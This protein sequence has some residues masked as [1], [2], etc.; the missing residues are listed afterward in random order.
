MGRGQTKYNE[1]RSGTG[2]GNSGLN[3]IIPPY[4]EDYVSE[5]ERF[6]QIPPKFQSLSLTIKKPG[7]VE[8]VYL[9]G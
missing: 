5:T 8:G 9:G 1:A 3:K 7:W 6:E 4:R 2:R